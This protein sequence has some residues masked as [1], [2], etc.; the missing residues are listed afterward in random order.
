MD[1]DT[2]IEL[3]TRHRKNGQEQVVVKVITED[4]KYIALGCRVGV[5]DSHIPEIGRVVEVFGYGS[6]INKE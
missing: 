3:L 5:I 4:G 6:K 2:L 1:I